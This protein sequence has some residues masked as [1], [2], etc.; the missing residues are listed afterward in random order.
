[1]VNPLVQMENMPVKLVCPRCGY[2]E[3]S[4]LGEVEFNEYGELPPCRECGQE[5]DE[6]CIEPDK[7]AIKLREKR[8]FKDVW[9]ES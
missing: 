4:T 8:G 9:R 6:D 2:I 5:M 1:M 7:R 3:Y